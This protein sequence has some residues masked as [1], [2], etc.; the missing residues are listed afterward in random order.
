MGPVMVN[1]VK[2]SNAL[3]G[4]APTLRYGDARLSVTGQS[5]S[6]WGQQTIKFGVIAAAVALP[7]VFGSLGPKPGEGPTREN[8]E[9]GYLKL[10]AIGTMVSND[11]GGSEDGKK[12]E[13]KI[14][15]LFQFNKDTG[16]LYTAVLLVETGMTLLSKMKSKDG[17]KGGCLTP[18][19]ALGSDLTQRILKEM[20][21]SLEVSEV[22]N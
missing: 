19:S 22:E 4:Y 14:K 7:S 17:L 6:E 11:N 2:R 9:A 5:W 15:G 16:Y 3:L 21:T 13:K 20:D 18:A 1:C 12:T 10:H 8:M